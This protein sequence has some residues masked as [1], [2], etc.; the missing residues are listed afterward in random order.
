MFL[1][2]LL[3]KSYD[4]PATLKHDNAFLWID[5]MARAQKFADR[6]ANL[7]WLQLLRPSW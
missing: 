2:L 1:S 7:N 3:A 6:F 5:D 4:S